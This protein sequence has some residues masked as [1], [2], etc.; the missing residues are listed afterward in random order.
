[1]KDIDKAAVYK[2]LQKVMADRTPEESVHLLQDIIVN[3]CIFP[4]A[5]EQQFADMSEIDQQIAEFMIKGEKI[6]AVK[7][8]R[9]LLGLGLKEAKDYVEANHEKVWS[10]PPEKRHTP[11]AKQQIAAKAWMEKVAK[12]YG[13]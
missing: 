1:M 13:I 12:D 2:F 3:N 5:D 9:D 8:A 6:Q 7:T 11:L 4:G 10:S